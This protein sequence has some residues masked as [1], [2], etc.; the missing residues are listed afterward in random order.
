M[1]TRAAHSVVRELQ[2]QVAGG[3]RSAVEVTQE[4]LKQLRSVEDKVNSFIT[5]DEEHALAQ[6]RQH[7]VRNGGCRGVGAGDGAGL[8]RVCVH[9]CEQGGAVSGNREFKTGDEP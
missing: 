3:Q 1:S 8:G 6:V 9:V 5:V 2:Q 4:Y 7:V